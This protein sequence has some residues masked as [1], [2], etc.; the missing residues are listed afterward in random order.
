MTDPL[1]AFA[2]PSPV[3]SVSAS[4]PLDPGRDEGREMLERE[5][6]DQQYQREFSGPLRQALNDLLTWLDDRVGTIGGVEIPD[7]PLII[8]ALLTIV[9][10]LTIVLVRPRLQRARDAGDPLE[11]ESGLSAADL[12]NRA[13]AHRREERI[14]DACRD[15]F[16][17]VV[18]AAEEREVLGEMLGRTATEAGRE[19]SR[20]Y[21]SEARRISI[22]A[23]LFNLSRYGGRSS[24]EQDFTSLQELDAAL[25]AAAPALGGAAGAAPMV[26]PR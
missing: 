19:L 3:L 22:S 21:P 11:V 7:G 24:T 8:L 2:E 16:R 17:A 14:D 9:V 26:A 5:L 1:P 13:L 15:L 4:V 20:A 25:D 12:R 10:V 18:R 23:D 6:A